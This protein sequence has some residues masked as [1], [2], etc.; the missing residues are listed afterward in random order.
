MLK[1]L[2]KWS[3]NTQRSKKKTSITN[4]A[5]KRTKSSYF[6]TTLQYT[7]TTLPKYF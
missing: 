2:G 7:W 5:F 6:K 1:E 4:E 3:N